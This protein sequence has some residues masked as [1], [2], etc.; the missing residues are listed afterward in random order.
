MMDTATATLKEKAVWPDWMLLPES[1][2]VYSG[3][4]EAS[5]DGLA[6]GP[7]SLAIGVFDGMHLGH[8]AVVDSAVANARRSHGLAGLLTFE[9]HPSRV[10]GAPEPTRLLMPESWKNERSIALG[11]DA[12]IWKTFSPEFA[13]LEATEFVR[14]LKKHLPR[15]SSIHVGTNYRFGRKRA[16]DVTMLNRIA[17]DLGLDVFSVDRIQHNGEVISS[18]RL[19]E[20]L[21]AGEMHHVNLMLG[22][23]YQSRGPVV[24]GKQLGRK[25]GFPTLNILWQPEASPR[26]GVYSVELRGE[27][28][29]GRWLP[30]IANYGIRPTL[31]S[32]SAP[33]L[34]VH[35]LGDCP[36]GTGDRLRV[37]WL[38]FIRPEQRFDSVEALK[39]QI[40]KDIR[41][42]RK[43]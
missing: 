22:H 40:G 2:V 26:Y 24:E 16:G 33:V 1:R 43:G 36:F 25:I 9:P 20:D 10:V 14:W 28:E 11:V 6:V 32:G 30:G 23:P 12:V 37:N 5:I 35:M 31:D 27:S 41:K 19:R 13:A 38:K 3:D 15:L 29:S 4:N 18:S 39:E 34:E 7:L 8:Q 42:V 21:A 17:R